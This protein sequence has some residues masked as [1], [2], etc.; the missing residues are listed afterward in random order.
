MKTARLS[1]SLWS[2]AD[3]LRHP[4]AGKALRLSDVSG[5]L[6]VARI[7]ILAH[8]GVQADEGAIQTKV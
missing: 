2:V 5:S 1:A 7:P 3:L 8:G 6:K 4:E